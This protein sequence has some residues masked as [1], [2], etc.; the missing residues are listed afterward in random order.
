[1]SLKQSHTTQQTQYAKPTD[2]L[3]VFEKLKTD[4]TFPKYE[5]NLNSGYKPSQADTNG[6]LFRYQL[7]LSV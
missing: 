1:M 6:T 4:Q 7:C 2:Q 5:E 3:K